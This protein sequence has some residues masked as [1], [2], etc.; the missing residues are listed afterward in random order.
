[1]K[2]LVFSLF[3]LFFTYSIFGQIQITNTS[4][5][6]TAGQML[7]ANEINESGEP[8]AEE[9]G[10]D[11]DLLDPAVLYSPDSISY[12]LGIDNYEYSRYQ[13]GTIV[14]RSGM[15]LH[16]IWAPVIG[17]AANQET[18][19]GFDGSFT[20]TANGFNEDDELIK[21]IMHF[22]M[23]SN[24]TP[25]ANPWPQFAEFYEGDPHLPQA[26]ANDFA[27]DF[28]SLR[29]DRSK[30]N[31]VLNPAAIGQALM[32]Q[33]LWA[34]DMLGAYHDGDDNGIDPDGTV[35]P[36]SAGSPN[37]DPTNNVFY[38]GNALDGFIGQ[39][40]TA[41]GI[42]KVKFLQTKFAYDGTSLGTVDP[43]TYDPANGIQYFPHMVSVTEEIVDAT[44]P[45]KPS[46]FQVVDETSNLWDQFSLLW[47]TL[48]F[49]NMMDPNNNESPAHTAYHSVFDGNPFPASASETGTPGPFDLMK[50]MSKVIFKN[51]MAMHWNSANGTYVDE[52]ALNGGN[53]EMGNNVSTV[54]AGYII[55]ALS[56]FQK[57]FKG[58]PL[59][60]MALDAINGQVNFILTSLK[61]SDG[62]YSNSFNF[63]TG[64]DPSATEVTSQ[65]AAIRGLYAAYEVTNDA[66]TLTAANEAYEYLINNFY[67]PSQN[68]FLT[69]AND[70]T[71][72]YTPSCVAIIAGALRGASLQGQYADAP[73]IY[74]RFFLNVAGTMQLSEAE[75][76]GESG[77]DSDGDGI[78]FVTEQ[79]DNLPP[80]FA[81]EAT[82]TIVTDVNSIEDIP[83]HF[84]LNQNYPNP[85]NP[86][87]Q[88]SYAISQNGIVKLTVYDVLGNEIEEL[89]NK[90][91]SAGNYT[92][93]FDASKYSSGI[94]F[95]KIASSNFVETKK[96]L[97]LK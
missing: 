95:Y 11:L 48:N 80:V 3:L 94:Y 57:E 27:S 67:I 77:G 53:V 34:Q 52:S 51:L 14:S 91:Q 89:V 37:F 54:N 8:F 87:T 44:M 79:P 61:N 25:P 49:T 9:L 7:L 58:T 83:N 50:G 35:T 1:M 63:D 4:I 85:F 82:L 18:D 32:K 69:T 71:A 96:M 15:G 40:L 64:V 70:N 2:K 55:V 68:A 60:Q 36:D 26:V 42:N 28:A 6:H 97:L 24:Q 45:P 81:T 86:S 90:N 74:T 43:A 59:E 56:L 47:G 65:G 21:N 5:Y 20:G 75:P 31:K 19:P 23:L 66:A 46:S 41:E 84:T 88:I 78:P 10:Y 76:T 33:Y 62:S 29:W 39:V 22:S 73:I 12:T 72:I 17:A 30:M 13:L 38:G 92:V 93:N 16:L